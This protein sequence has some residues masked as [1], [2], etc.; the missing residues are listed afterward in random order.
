[1]HR[2][3]LKDLYQRVQKA[4]SKA[5]YKTP[6][7]A[8]T[9][10]IRFMRQRLGKINKRILLPL[11]AVILIISGF[12]VIAGSQWAPVTISSGEE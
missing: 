7:N 11:L 4:T 5:R 12:G 8:I 6:T 1:M 2:K 10:P 9:R 3:L